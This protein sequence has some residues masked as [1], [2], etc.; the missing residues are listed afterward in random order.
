MKK[1]Y[2][3]IRL[4][5]ELCTGTSNALAHYCELMG[6]K[7]PSVIA[8][9]LLDEYVLSPAFEEKLRLA[10]KFGKKLEDAED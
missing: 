6:Y 8:K 3:P 10:M 4:Q 7:Q 5:G 2:D 9:S 1:Q